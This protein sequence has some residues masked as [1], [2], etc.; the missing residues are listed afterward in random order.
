[1][2]II[3]GIVAGVYICC[4]FCVVFVQN[5]N[6]LVIRFFDGNYQLFNVFGYCSRFIN[7]ILYDY[8]SL[9]RWFLVNWFVPL[10]IGAP[11][12]AF[13]KTE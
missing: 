7:G 10:Q 3:Y 13:S 4:N 5:Y 8:A 2:Y 1:M 12:M 11:D 6:I 9:N